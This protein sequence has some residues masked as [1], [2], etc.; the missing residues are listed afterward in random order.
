[1]A[2]LANLG[3]EMLVLLSGLKE[4][5]LLLGFSADKLAIRIKLSSHLDKYKEDF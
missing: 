3:V 1:M 5:S 4:K 2:A